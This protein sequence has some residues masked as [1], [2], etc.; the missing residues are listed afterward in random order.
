MHHLQALT[1]AA[2]SPVFARL[3]VPTVPLDYET[4]SEATCAAAATTDPSGKVLT[5]VFQGESWNVV[6]GLS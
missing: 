2:G 6:L 1:L 5:V 4:S 3:A